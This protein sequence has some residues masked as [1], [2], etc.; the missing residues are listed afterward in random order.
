MKSDAQLAKAVAYDRRRRRWTFSVA[1]VPGLTAAEIAARSEVIAGYQKMRVGV[2]GDLQKYGFHVE[3]DGPGKIHGVIV[4][5]TEP[6][7]TTWDHLRTLMPV[8]DNP[9]YRG[10]NSV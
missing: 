5:T 10:R 4:F 1:C 3:S 9:H 6:D 2:A 7:G 8:Q